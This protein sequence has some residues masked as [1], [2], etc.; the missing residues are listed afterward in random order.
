V[1]EP[2]FQVYLLDEPLIMITHRPESVVH[3]S[4][5]VAQTS[6]YNT[7]NTIQERQIGFSVVFRDVSASASA[8]LVIEIVSTRHEFRSGSLSE[9]RFALSRHKAHPTFPTI[10]ARL[11]NIA[12]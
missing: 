9:A 10:L 4:L 6:R 11:C 12:Q 7:H 2:G 8:P 1:E 5:R 3:I